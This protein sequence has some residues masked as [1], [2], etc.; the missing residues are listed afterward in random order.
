MVYYNFLIPCY[1][2]IFYHIKDIKTLRQIAYAYCHLLVI[3][4]ARLQGLPKR[5]LQSVA[6][7][8]T[9][10]NTRKLHSKLRVCRV[11]KQLYCLGS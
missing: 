11:R 10:L 6:N 8:F 2:T 7:I 5:V 4:A 1:Y 9:K 3:Y